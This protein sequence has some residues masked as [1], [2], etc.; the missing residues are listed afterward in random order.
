MVF[1]KLFVIILYV[2]MFWVFTANRIDYSSENY[3]N[4]FVIVL[5]TA[6]IVSIWVWLPIYIFN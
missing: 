2:L 5:G 4:L 3:F 1:V 6:I